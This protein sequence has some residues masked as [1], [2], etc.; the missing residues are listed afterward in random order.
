MPENNLLAQLQLTSEQFI[1]ISCQAPPLTKQEKEWLSDNYASLSN[2]Q[3]LSLLNAGLNK[4]GV[5]NLIKKASFVHLHHQLL[6]EQ[7]NF[8]LTIKEKENIL[9]LLINTLNLTNEQQEYL[10][11]M[12]ISFFN[13][14]EWQIDN[15]QKN[16]LLSFGLNK[17][18]LSK[19]QQENLLNLSPE[20]FPTFSLTAEQK[21]I[22]QSLAPL[23]R[24]DKYSLH[25]CELLKELH[26]KPTALLFF[27]QEE[28]LPHPN[29]DFG[30]QTSPYLPLKIKYLAGEQKIFAHQANWAKKEQNKQAIAEEKLSIIASLVQFLQT[31]ED[32]RSYPQ[33]DWKKFADNEASVSLAD[34]VQFGVLTHGQANI[35]LILGLKTI[36]KY[37]FFELLPLA[38]E[39]N[40]QDFRQVITEN[41]LEKWYQNYLN[42]PKKRPLIQWGKTLEELH[43]K[44]TSPKIDRKELAKLISQQIQQALSGYQLK[45]EEKV[46]NNWQEEEIVD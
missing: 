10:E 29:F 16:Q 27:A 13:A 19:E 3:Q 8:G 24:H 20:R 18:N 7:N 25:A 38:C 23:T 21:N 22:L 36:P 32:E 30:A 5:D 15:T 9:R 28:I 45:P 31:I 14:S 40:N 26:L 1:A 6:H 44:T 41:G 34:W 4:L 33:L 17:I 42:N 35:L 46:I 37:D 43:E 12:G 39:I 2:S 11:K